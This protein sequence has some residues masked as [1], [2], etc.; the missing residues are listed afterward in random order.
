MNETVVSWAEGRTD[1]AAKCHAEELREFGQ[2]LTK[3]NLVLTVDR[4]DRPRPELENTTCESADFGVKS[5][6]FRG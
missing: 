6:A 5:A 3:I 1:M 2:R 4:V